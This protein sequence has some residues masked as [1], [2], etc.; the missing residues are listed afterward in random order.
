[1]LT[2]EESWGFIIAFVIIGLIIAPF[3][4]KKR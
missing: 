3:V 2:P 4:I 1:M